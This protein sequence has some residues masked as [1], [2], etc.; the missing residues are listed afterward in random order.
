MGLAAGCD[1]EPIPE[2]VTFEPTIRALFQSHCVRCHGAGGTLNG[3][4]RS[5]GGAPPSRAYLNQL[6]DSGD[7]TADPVTGAVPDSCRRGARWASDQ[8]VIYVRSKGSSRMP[9]APSE[10]LTD[11]EIA[12][13]D[14][15]AQDPK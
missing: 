4:P 5:L 3:D 6:E 12:L 14:R 9:P 8:I 2:K 7:C 11:R 13:I 15:W 1:D 10:P